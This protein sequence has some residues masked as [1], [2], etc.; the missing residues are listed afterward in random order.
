MVQFIGLG[1]DVNHVVQHPKGMTA[2]HLCAATTDA[3]RQA[4]AMIVANMLLY[5]GGNP[6]QENKKGAVLQHPN[7]PTCR[8]GVPSNGP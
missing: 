5:A 1:A 3:T 7:T 2:L 8:L 6:F 4:E